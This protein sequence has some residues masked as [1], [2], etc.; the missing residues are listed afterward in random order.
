LI[1]VDDFKRINDLVGERY[2]DIELQEMVEFA[3]KDKDGK[4]N[5]DEFK[6]VVL[7]EYGNN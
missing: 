3:D 7:R 4:I 6:A 5:W 1:T 2:T